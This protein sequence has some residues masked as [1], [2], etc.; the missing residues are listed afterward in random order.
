MNTRYR[1][2]VLCSLISLTVLLAGCSSQPA[3]D[4]AGAPQSFAAAAVS[5]STQVNTTPDASAASG[6][7]STQTTSTGSSTTTD[8]ST[9]GSANSSNNVV[10]NQNKAG[11]GA[12]AT[13]GNPVAPSSTGKSTQQGDQSS[14]S[15]SSPASAPNGT[16]TEDKQE[17]NPNAS[18]E[19]QSGQKSAAQAQDKQASNVTKPVDAVEKTKSKEI[20]Q[21]T[22]A[23]S[24][25]TKPSNG[26][27]SQTSDK[28]DSGISLQT[29]SKATSSNSVKVNNNSTSTGKA[30]T[31]NSTTGS[32]SSKANSSAAASKSKP[33]YS[34]TLQWS[35]FFDNE[36]QN[37]PSDK[38]WDLSGQQVTIKGYMGE[39][40][41][42]DKHWF[43]SFRH[44]VQN[45]PS[46]MATKPTGTKL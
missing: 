45:V 25:N 38:F 21:P 42:F 36:K 24:N 43:F 5:T 33:A 19:H 18:P 9:V 31:N 34:S 10:E 32:T 44:R 23:A 39:V 17:L 12:T 41:S 4:G 29:N 2:S 28:T 20:V 35:E 11:A 7:G 30:N 3:T 46:I 6:T 37:T 27:R 1:N 8:V 13:K 15:A 40:L 26:N 16:A 14:S 22:A